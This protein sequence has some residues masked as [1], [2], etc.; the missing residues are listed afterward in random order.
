M[1]QKEYKPKEQT[2]AQLQE[3]L[4]QSQRLQRQAEKRLAVAK[5][6]LAAI[7]N[8]PSIDIARDIAGACLK[9]LPNIRERAGRER[10]A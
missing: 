6:S 10:K 1:S 5:T 3:Q 2:K 7:R 4:A 9:A 8:E